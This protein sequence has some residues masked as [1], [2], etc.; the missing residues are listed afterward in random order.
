MTYREAQIKLKEIAESI[1]QTYYSCS[2]EE[3]YN[4]T[5]YQITHTLYI[6]T[7][8]HIKGRTWEEAF[9]KLDELMNPVEFVYTTEGAPEW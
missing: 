6:N 2:Y 1:G 3:T 8:H 4:S 5:L 9:C 7:L